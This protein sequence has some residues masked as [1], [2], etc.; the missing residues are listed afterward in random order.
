MF[1]LYHFHQSH[2]IFIFTPQKLSCPD[3]H[4]C[5]FGNLITNAAP[6]SILN[7]PPVH[8]H[9]NDRMSERRTS[10]DHNSFTG[11]NMSEVKPCVCPALAESQSPPADALPR[12]KDQYRPFRFLGSA[13]PCH[14]RISVRD[15]NHCARG[16]RIMNASGADE[17]SQKTM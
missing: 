1:K 17:M 15:I 2:Y 12:R 11:S 16:N 9:Q 6:S 13:L 8:G 10:G 14:Q 4:I 3:H 5:H 7:F